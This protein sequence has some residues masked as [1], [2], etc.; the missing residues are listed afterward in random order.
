MRGVKQGAHYIERKQNEWKHALPPILKMEVL[1][2]KEKNRI[3]K[4][5]LRSGIDW[6]WDRPNN[7]QWSYYLPIPGRTLDRQPRIKAQRIAEAMQNM[8]DLISEYRE[9]RRQYNLQIRI[10]KKQA[11]EK[12]KL[13]E[14][15]NTRLTDLRQLVSEY[16]ILNDSFFDGDNNYYSLT[17][18]QKNSEKTNNENS[19][20]FKKMLKNKPLLCSELD[21]IQ[22]QIDKSRSHEKL[23][24]E[25]GD[26]DDGRTWNSRRTEKELA[27]IQQLANEPNIEREQE[28]HAKK[29]IKD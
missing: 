28:K 12:N 8:P 9:Q 21:T 2:G 27:Y 26:Y 24:P 10:E 20:K 11:E 15:A 13:I 19:E 18:A 6:I 5:F 23:D 7:I 25:D 14:A 3:R 16:D 1:K 29:R 4:E 22:E 17:N